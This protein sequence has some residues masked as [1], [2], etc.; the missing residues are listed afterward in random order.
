M[1][2]AANH[3]DCRPQLDDEADE[4]GGDHARRDSADDHDRSLT[5]RHFQDRPDDAGNDDIAEG[6]QNEII[7]IQQSERDY[8]Q[9]G[10]H[11]N[12]DEAFRRISTQLSD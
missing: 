5:R 9:N 3:F 8:R 6:G 12:D 1:C 2:P 10:R 7:D 4:S 11:G